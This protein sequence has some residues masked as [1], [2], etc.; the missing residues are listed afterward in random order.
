MLDKYYWAPHSHPVLVL[1]DLLHLKP[2]GTFALSHLSGDLG[3]KKVDFIQNYMMPNPQNLFSCHRPNLILDFISI[4]CGS[5][6]IFV[7]VQSSYKFIVVDVAITITVKD[8][9]NSRH[10]Q[11]AG[12]ELC[13]QNI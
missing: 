8:I 11:L 5:V 3:Y 2:L 13:K 10:L 12:R 9:S 4:C 7:G 1:A 6:S